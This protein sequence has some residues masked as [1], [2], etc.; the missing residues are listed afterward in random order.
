MAIVPL[1]VRPRH[2][3]GR[4]RDKLGIPPGDADAVMLFTAKCY[5]PGV[6][7]A[8]LRAA[9]AGERGDQITVFRGALALPTDDLVLC[10]F[11]A[12]SRAAVKDACERVGW[13][14]ERV[15]ESVWISGP[16]GEA[17]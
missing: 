5:W 11:D 3:A 6:T 16:E 1:H 7:D 4:R 17:R 2:P 13:P 10:L 9:L 8:Q 15:I 12:E 14:C